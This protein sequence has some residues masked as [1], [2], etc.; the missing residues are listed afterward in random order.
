M[1][2]LHR[3]SRPGFNLGKQDRPFN[4]TIC[5]LGGGGYFNS[6]FLYKPANDELTI[7]LT[8]SV[9]ASATFN[10]SQGWISGGVGIYLGFEGS[11]EKS[12]STHSAFSL[13]LYVSFMGHCDV[14]GL[15]YALRRFRLLLIKNL[16]ARNW[17]MRLSC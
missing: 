5:I 4:I 17:A 7:G 15:I 8:L 11:F 16:L 6:N 3:W 2:T 14:L 1:K 10:F 13:S 9:H 12:P